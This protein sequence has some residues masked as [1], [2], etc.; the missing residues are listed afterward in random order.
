[1]T[2]TQSSTTTVVVPCGNA[3]DRNDYSYPDVV[4][5]AL[6]ARDGAKVLRAPANLF[7]IGWLTQFH[8]LVVVLYQQLTG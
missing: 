1:M 6:R 5:G 7:T 3:S 8:Y 2:V 4:R